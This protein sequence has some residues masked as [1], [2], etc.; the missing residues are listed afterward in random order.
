MKINSKT[1]GMLDYA[2]VVLLL[3]S[4]TLFSLGSVTSTFTYVIASIHL[5]LTLCTDFELGVFKIIPFKIHGIIEIIV[6][7]TLVGIAFYLGSIEGSASKIFYLCFA[8]VVFIA[9]LITDFKVE[10]VVLLKNNNCYSFNY[11]KCYEIIVADF[12]SPPALLREIR[13]MRRNL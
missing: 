2:L 4:P 11:N 6:A 12:F 5:I 10:E 13:G 3:I 7:V 9:W 8:F 1:H